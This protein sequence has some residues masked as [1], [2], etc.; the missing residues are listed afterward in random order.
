MLT[1]SHESV[2]ANLKNILQKKVLNNEQLI[3]AK[4]YFEKNIKQR[5]VIKTGGDQKN[6]REEAKG[7]LEIAIWSKKKVRAK[8]VLKDISNVYISAAI[9]QRQKRLAD[10]LSF[11]NKQLPILN[12]K[13]SSIHDALEVIEKQPAIKVVN[14]TN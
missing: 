2:Q 11:L 12:E 10:G 5:L 9:E 8:K 13:T 3:F 6:W 7:I 1:R 14:K 4:G